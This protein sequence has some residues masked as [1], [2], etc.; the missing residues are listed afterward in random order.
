MVKQAIFSIQVGGLNVTA[1]FSPFLIS[2]SVTDNVGTDSDTANITLDNKDGQLIIPANGDPCVISLGWAG[3][4][5]R[6]IFRG[7]IDKV[8]SH[9]STSGRTLTITA[10]GLPTKEKAKEPQ[11]RHMDNMTVEDALKKAGDYAGMTSYNIDPKVG[12]QMVEYLEMK[13][14]SFIHFGERLAREYGGNF[15]VKD[16]EVEMSARDGTYTASVTA[17][18]G[19]N[20][21]TW[22][23]EP[24]IGRMEYGKTKARHYD[25]KE[26]KWKEEVEETVHD[27]VAEHV[28]RYHQ[29]DGDKAKAKVNSDRATSERD[30]GGGSVKIEGNNAAIPDGLLILVGTRG[31]V[32]GSYR[33]ETVTHNLNSSGWT[34]S[35]ALKQPQEGG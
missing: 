24:K 30:A 21:H 20:L 11:K 9:G 22:D 31:G 13:D 34:T 23:I 16:T 5:V 4:G 27:A 7:R 14:E 8:R 12:S 18:W 19:V 17:T 26:A 32:D 33:I 10:K 1:N 25:R 15:R 2:M 28:A 29:A 35:L 6:E 3:G